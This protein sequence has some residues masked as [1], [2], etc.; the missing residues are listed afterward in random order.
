MNP[1]RDA[2]GVNLGRLAKVILAV[3]AV[4]VYLGSDDA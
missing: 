1:G 3:I 2:N 4:S